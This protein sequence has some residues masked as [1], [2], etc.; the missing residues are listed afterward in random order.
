VLL[1]VIVWAPDWLRGIGLLPTDYG[2]YSSPVLMLLLPLGYLGIIAYAVV[3]ARPAVAVTVLFSVLAVEVVASM[4]KLGVGSNGVVLYLVVYELALILP[5][6][7]AAWLGA[8]RQ[9]RLHTP[10]AVT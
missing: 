3:D 1:P 2:D 6:A 10:D 4:L 5:V 8:R 7:A 9:A